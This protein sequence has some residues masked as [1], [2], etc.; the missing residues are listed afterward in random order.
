MASARIFLLSPARLDGKRG[1]LLF[2]PG[3][4]FPM[5]AGLRTP[6]GMPIGHVY[7]FLSGLYFRGKLAYAERFARP[8]GENPALGAG[9][10]VIT[11]SRGLVPAA[12]RVC[13]EHLDEFSQIDIHHK[14]ESFRKPLVRDAKMIL[15]TLG[16]D[17]EIVLLGSV[18]SVKYVDPLLEVLG[19][20]LLF[21]KDF[22]G[23]GD[24]SRGGLMLRCV[25]SGTELPY[26]PVL[27]A[28]RRGTRPPKLEPRRAKD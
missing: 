5:A 11:P 12:M 3:A 22:V 19:D 7:R 23:R 15:D 21:P 8:R 28:T 9:V 16:P 6:E 24:M 17:D 2:N 27:G 13:L 25:Q 14:H 10:L 20:R 4:T 26:I 1:A 18:A